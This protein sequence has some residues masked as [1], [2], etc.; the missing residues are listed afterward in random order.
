MNSLHIMNT[1][2]DRGH[3]HTT[4]SHFF[5]VSYPNERNPLVGTEV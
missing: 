2:N 3:F 5:I 4:G 1:S